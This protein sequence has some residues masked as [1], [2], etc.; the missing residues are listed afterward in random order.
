MIKKLL[1]FTH[2]LFSALIFLSVACGNEP[3]QQKPDNP[4]NETESNLPIS[5]CNK[6]IYEVNVR[7][8]SAQGNFVGLQNDLPR[9][10]ELGVDILWL[11]PIHPVGEKNRNGSKGSPYSVKD[12]L[13]IN[14]DYGDEA[15]L[16]SLVATA[17][18]AKI[19]IWL[20]WVANHTAWDHVWTTEHPDYY[21]AKNGQRPYSPEGWADVI[22]LD[23]SNSAM[24][25][26]MIDAMKYWVSEFDIDGFRC[27]YVSGVPVDFWAKAK[28]EVNA[29]KKITWLAE[30]DNADYMSVFDYDYAWAFNTA[31]NDFAK[32]K[33]VSKLQ[34]ACQTLFNNDK[35][36]EKGRMVYL[37][38]HD[39]NAYDGTEFTRLGS[40]VLP[41]TALY[42]T[43]YNLPLLYNGQEVGANKSTGLFDVSQ[44]PW[45]PVNTTMQNLI[46]KLVKLKHSQPALES[47]KNRGALNF[48]ATDNA[49]VFAYSRTSATNE[50]LVLLNFSAAPA[51]FRFNGTTPDGDFVNWLTDSK[52]TFAS[53]V[54]V[55][56]PANGYA[57]YVK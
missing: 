27:D 48:Y 12:Y 35:Y 4:T 22:Q 30:S 5:D 28:S 54:K 46:K 3:E 32:S 6:V 18:E 42:F 36:R 47:G 11:M 56:L 10:R 50:V 16:K 20:D 17:H 15:Q 38:N 44:V 43:I 25:T 34:T 23:F 8:F 29:V 19:E 49:Q 52:Q 53:G 55:E 57:V 51:S 24:Q 33:D 1:Y 2:L 41:L 31:L 13:K 9:L 7:N 39:L 14:P 26:A 40:S 45:T 37:S 21:A